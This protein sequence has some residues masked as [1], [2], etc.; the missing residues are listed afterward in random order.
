MLHTLTNT[1][2]KEVNMLVLLGLSKCRQGRCLSGQFP[3]ILS[4]VLLALASLVPWS[5][6]LTGFQFLLIKDMSPWQPQLQAEPLGKQPPEGK[7]DTSD[8][9]GDEDLVRERPWHACFT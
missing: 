5:P 4:D 9:D 1:I 8:G 6:A 2:T 3:C 7:S